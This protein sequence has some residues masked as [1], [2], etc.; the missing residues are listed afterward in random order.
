[1]HA[2]SLRMR[3]GGAHGERM[4]SA[5]LRGTKPSLATATSW[6]QPEPTR[7]RVSPASWRSACRPWNDG[8]RAVS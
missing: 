8:A 2:R 3:H 1:M 4:Y 6:Q 5:A 7:R